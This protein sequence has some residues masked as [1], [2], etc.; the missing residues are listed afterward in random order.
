[1]TTIAY[2]KP[3]ED[4]IAQLSA[5]GHVTHT[6]YKKTSITIHH[7]AGILSHED[8]LR[9]W[10]TRPSSAH[11]DVDGAGSV[12]Q[13]V[14]VDE[15][16]W[17]VGNT[18][19]NQ[20]SISIE[21]SNSTLAP[22]WQVAE[23][24]W[25]EAA[26]LAGWLFAHEI[27]ARPDASNF[28]EH[29]HWSATGCPGPYVDS[30]WPQMVAAAQAAYDSFMGVVSPASTTQAVILPATPQALKLGDKGPDVST[31]QAQ[32][33]A[34]GFGPV[35]VDGD[36]GPATQSA[37]KRA[38]I[39]I[40][41]TSD[42]IYGP[43]TK[44]ALSGYNVNVPAPVTTPAVSSRATLVVQL[45]SDVHISADGK[46]GN[47][48]DLAMQAV[49][50]AAQGSIPS[51]VRPLQGYVGAAADGAWG[52]NSKA[53]LVATVKKIQSHLGVVA[54][55]DWGKNTQAAYITARNANLNKF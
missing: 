51:N 23:V 8:I 19:G 47:G 28:F 26:R 3:V 21:M 35:S 54:D 45:Q 44:A 5:T 52:P 46:W 55:G 48:T 13:Y 50:S 18:A 12:A 32:L 27:G 40:H 10:T 9:V 29:K 30:V 11:F 37:V 6:A 36:F 42:G 16:A 4:L 49:A 25:Q 24:T 22:D 1:M 41:V 17:A 34:K 7:N 15:Y 31:M 14:K 33:N 39:V 53:A 43:A 2:D 20:S 38:Q